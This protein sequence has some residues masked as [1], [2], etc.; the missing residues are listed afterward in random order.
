MSMG[1]FTKMDFKGLTGMP[2]R[3]GS[4]KKF[5]WKKH[6]KALGICAGVLVFL[7]LFVVFGIVLPAKRTY[8][9]AKVAYVHAKAA[10][11]GLKTQN[12]DIA[13][14][15]LQNTKTELT[16]TQQDF[17][18]MWY[19]HFIPIANWYY[20]DGDHLLKAGQYGMNAAQ[21]TVDAI[22]PYADLLGFKG[23]GS[24]AGGTTQSR[25]QT[26]VLTLGK[27][28]PRLDDLEQQLSLARTEIDAVSP[29]HYPPFFGGQ[30]VRD[31]LSQLKSYT[32]ETVGFLQQAKPL[33]K[34]LPNVLGEPKEQKYLILFQNDA[35]LRPT[36]GFLTA[37]A[38]F[39]VEHGVIHVETSQDIYTLDATIPSSA[40]PTAPR[41]LQKYL[42]VGQ[43]NLR[44]SNLSPD[45]VTSMNTFNS[46]YQHSSEYVPVDGIIT[47]DTHAL[48]AAMNILGDIDAGGTTFSTKENLYCK[49]PDVIY[50]LESTAD[51]PVGYQRTD[52]K[53]VIGDL[54]YGIMNK[55]FTSPI[56]QTFGPLFQAMVA[57][58]SQ[59]HLLFDLYNTDAQTGLE[60]LNAA[61]RILPF[62]GDYFHM[63]MANLGGAKAN[64]YV[65][66]KL[67]HKYDIGGDG[68][69]TKTVTVTFKNPYSPSDCNLEHGNLC[70]NAPLRTWLRIYVPQ[71]SQ[72][73][74]SSG[75]QVTVTSYNELGKTVFDGFITPQPL[76]VST[77]TIS[78][79]LP[80]KLDSGSPLPLMIQ[81][82][83]GIA[84]Q[85]VTIQSGSN[86]L[87][88]F[89]LDTDKTVNLSLR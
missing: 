39:T 28:T 13:D 11:T 46:L 37:Y 60:S 18:S 55:A 74:D 66:E 87:Q 24:F 65:S 16:K 5:N 67:V 51:R 86:V 50:Q 43:L 30:K 89:T 63:N 80:F 77:F 57:E 69:I 22:K 7:I 73:V 85:D 64:M 47:V 15:E 3:N 70:L 78:Y 76:G 34:V 84:S 6:K 33:V 59:K 2:R 8:T 41:L 88:Q 53:S 12:I 25:I 58:T 61:G 26:A 44:D 29:N 14:S 19:L 35:E 52:R 36:G 72:L 83:P 38:I 23:A 31:Q 27:V 10:L 48:V 82:Q 9:Q 17:Y 49:C 68:S 45:F 54:M 79:K 56:K 71:G 40:K 21:I 81:K 75:S 62:T 20:D 1:G 4:K 42:N 32:D